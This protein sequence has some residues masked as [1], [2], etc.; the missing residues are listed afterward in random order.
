M[1][2]VYIT[3]DEGD[4]IFCEKVIFLIYYDGEWQEIGSAFSNEYGFVGIQY[5]PLL[6]AGTYG[7]KVKIQESDYYLSD[8]K[9]GT[10]TILK[11]SS[12]I[13]I[14]P[15]TASFG[16]TINFQATLKDDESNPIADREIH[17]YIN[18]NGDWTYVTS[19][20]TDLFGSVSASW[21]VNAY[22][23]AYNIKAVFLGDEFYSG[24]T[25]ILST[26]LL[27]KRRV[28]ALSD[29]SI[30]GIA[31]QEI[32][33]TTRLTDLQ[34]NPIASELILFYILL[35]RTLIGSSYTDHNGYASITYLPS[36]SAGTYTIM[37][38]YGGSTINEP[39]ETSGTL[40][41]AQP[42]ALTVHGRIYEYWDDEWVFPRL[43]TTTWYEEHQYVLSWDDEVTFRA[44]TTSDGNPES[45][46][47]VTF[48]YGDIGTDTWTLI[49]F[50]ATDSEGLAEVI[51]QWTE[52]EIIR[53]I[54][55]MKVTTDTGITEY[56]T[57]FFIAIDNRSFA[58]KFSHNFGYS[59]WPGETYKVP[60]YW[61]GLLFFIQR[62][63]PYYVTVY[64]TLEFEWDTEYWYKYY[65]HVPG[66]FTKSPE[67]PLFGMLKHYHNSMS[68]PVFTHEFR[69]KGMCEN[70]YNFLLW[71]AKLE[72]VGYLTNFVVDSTENEDA[73][74]EWMD[75]GEEFEVIVR[76]ETIIP[77]QRYETRVTYQVYE[78]GEINHTV[79][80]ETAD[81]EEWIYT[82]YPWI[83]EELEKGT[84]YVFSDTLFYFLPPW[85]W[86]DP[87]GDYYLKFEQHPD[88]L[89]KVEGKEYNYTKIR[90][91]FHINS[92]KMLQ[93]YVNN[94]IYEL[95]DVSNEGP[96]NLSIPV[97]IT[98]KEPVSLSHLRNLETHYNIS[99]DN[100]N[101]YIDIEGEKYY[102]QLPQINAS[103]FYDSI[104][105]S[106]MMIYS[107][108]GYMLKESLI[109]LQSLPEVLLIDP[110]I[111]ILSQKYGNESFYVDVEISDLFK[112]LSNKTFTSDSFSEQS[113]PARVIR[114]SLTIVLVSVGLVNVLLFRKKKLNLSSYFKM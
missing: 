18:D 30:Q 22:P 54:Y 80:A 96:A 105:T 32:K 111:Y 15:I 69:A 16:E 59:Q 3:D 8:E 98:F 107:L 36:L 6:P 94:R 67:Y 52:P 102:G 46:V 51:K 20:I 106:E 75:G 42:T 61:L 79:E 38:F 50:D 25:E 29:P 44:T 109:P 31:N 24:Q 28:T 64:H 63:H 112:F 82:P 88:R 45:G 110:S 87:P 12:T 104:D 83:Y 76:P 72:Q 93:N 1:I 5:I 70:F 71:V 97:L 92:Q 89:I 49:G 65:S 53:G 7:F 43:V 19:G 57:D 26:G 17:F 23:N 114:T 55:D 108:R 56:K 35:S 84:Q 68:D 85:A 2:R 77:N 90:V 81:A 62:V 113:T 11:E 100:Y 48:Y 4:P 74:E 66:M 47:T 103:Q 60:I 99:I 95:Q 21:V 41:V 27:I 86:D 78:S 58:P 13:K 9:V 39:I 101:F 40:I 14:Y 73:L 33:I 91:E 37:V 10:L 34:G